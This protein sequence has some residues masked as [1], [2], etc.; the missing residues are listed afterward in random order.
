[1]GCAR[2]SMGLA[3][4]VALGCGDGTTDDAGGA[5][6]G[7]GGD[8]AGGGVPQ[9][10]PFDVEVHEPSGDPAAGVLVRVSAGEFVVETATGDDGV[11]AL[12]VDPARGPFDVTV[13]RRDTIAVSFVAVDAVPAPIQLAAR[14][15]GVRRFAGDL[16]RLDPAD[17]VVIALDEPYRGV[18]AAPAQPRFALFGRPSAWLSA[19]EVDPEGNV[20]AVG[21]LEA[22]EGD[23]NDITLEASDLGFRR[24]YTATLPTTGVV[25]AASLQPLSPGLPLSAIAYTAGAE[26]RLVGG[27]RA[28]EVEGAVASFEIVAGEL[29]APDFVTATYRSPNTS[30]VL[31]VDADRASP[32]SVPELVS[33]EFAGSSTS[34]TR[35]AAEAPG[36]SAAT[37][38]LGTADDIV[39]IVVAPNATHGEPV[40]FPAPPTGL[41]VTDLAPGTSS[42]SAQPGLVFVEDETLLPAALVGTA[43]SARLFLTARSVVHENPSGDERCENLFDDDGDGLVDCDDDACDSSNACTRGSGPLEGLCTTVADCG[44]DV[45]SAPACLSTEQGYPGGYCVQTC[46]LRTD[47]CP[48]GSR[49]AFDANTPWL[50]SEGRGLCFASCD[51]G[52]GGD[53]CAAHHFCHAN[54]FCLGGGAI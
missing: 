52:G 20:V 54:G 10:V 53:D 11:A 26:P 30:L 39:W 50:F 37:L 36:W 47:D 9:R 25:Q 19:L 34:D 27:G 16:D 1:M 21:G 51:P 44:S 29:P 48:D 7:G 40:T 23:R 28:L 22:Q 12:E 24:S 43:T 35:Y 15:R 32:V 3:T 41:T 31:T 45:D 6:E 38:S 4:L 14:R 18:T 8:G 17:S 42:F 33:R 49:C 46:D 13:A 2:I 5:A